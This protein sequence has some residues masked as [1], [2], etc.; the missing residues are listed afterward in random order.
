MSGSTVDLLIKYGEELY[1]HRRLYTYG[2]VPACILWL[3]HYETLQLYQWKY[4]MF[5]SCLVDLV[6]FI[7]CDISLFVT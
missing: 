5:I 7:S 4:S 1:F 2:V 3:N 6:A